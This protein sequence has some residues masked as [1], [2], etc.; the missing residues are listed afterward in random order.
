MQVVQAA[1]CRYFAVVHVAVLLSRQETAS[2]LIPN[3]SLTATHLDLYS[4]IDA[5]QESCH[6]RRGVQVCQEE[7]VVQG[8]GQGQGTFALSRHSL[9]IFSFN[10]C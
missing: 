6:R 9:H 5:A 3:Q 7:E 4:H 2:D 10:N 1:L 8:Q